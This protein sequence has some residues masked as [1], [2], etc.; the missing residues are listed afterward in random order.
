M[1]WP[2]NV[3]PPNC[4]GPRSSHVRSAIPL[5]E[6]RQRGHLFSRDRLDRISGPGPSAQTTPDYRDAR[7]FALE[8]RAQ[9]ARH[10]RAGRL[11]GTGA[12]QVNRPVFRNLRVGLI[13]CMRVQ[14]ART[15]YA[16]GLGVEVAVA[17]HVEDV[18]AG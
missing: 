12:V 18:G 14:P 1:D 10:A 17:A 7:A 4:S 8:R 9:L 16:N 13:Q 11:A 2:S 6:H 15:A 5:P 3:T